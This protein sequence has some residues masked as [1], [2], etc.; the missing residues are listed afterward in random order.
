MNL[1]DLF[2]DAVVISVYTN[3][4]AV[5]DGLK[6]KI[7]NRTYITTNLA[8]QLFPDYEED[9]QGLLTLVQDEIL[10]HYNAG[11]FA[12]PADTDPHKEADRYFAYYRVGSIKVWAIVDGD[13]LHLI[14]PEDY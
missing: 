1:M 2:E 5:D 8:R 10:K 3:D 9:F 12:Y 14:S 11:V 7:A 4:Q 6:V 13:G